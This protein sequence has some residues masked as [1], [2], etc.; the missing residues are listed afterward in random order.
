MQKLLENF[1]LDNEGLDLITD[2]DTSNQ[3]KN[4]DK[5]IGFSPGSKHFTKMWPEEY[6]IN[7]GKK[8]SEKS[9]KIVV[10][11]WKK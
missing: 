1:E 7:L 3:I 4:D 2:K 9:Y 10:V 6:Y 8:L 11:R 5:Y